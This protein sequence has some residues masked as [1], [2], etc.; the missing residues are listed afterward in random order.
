VGSAVATAAGVFV[1][2]PGNA[3]V[4]GAVVGAIASWVLPG[5]VTAGVDV[6]DE[7]QATMNIRNMEKSTAGFLRYESFTT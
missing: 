2:D 6:A 5:C 7:P 3:V 4:K 1:G